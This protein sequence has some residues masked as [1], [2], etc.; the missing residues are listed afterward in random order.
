[1]IAKGVRFNAVKQKGYFFNLAGKYLGT[2][3]FQFTMPCTNCKNTI[4]IKTDPETTEYLLVLGC[5]K[6][7]IDYDDSKIGVEKI[8]TPDEAVKLNMN[9]F[10]KLE[11]KRVDIIK[12]DEQRP[13]IQNLIKNKVIMI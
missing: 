6:Y 5:V 8:Q 1:M 2:Y 10:L 9:A 4:I 3:I 7:E 11:S 12:A 13:I